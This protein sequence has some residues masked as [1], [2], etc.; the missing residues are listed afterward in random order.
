ME[1]NIKSLNVI[2]TL[3]EYVTRTNVGF[4]Y[5][6]TNLLN[7]KKKQIPWAPGY[8]V[9]EVGILYLQ[10]KHRLV[11]HKLVAELVVSNPDRKK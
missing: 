1:I 3:V 10:D 2:F 6:K 7:R 4:L 5:M 11:D 9:T 8:Y